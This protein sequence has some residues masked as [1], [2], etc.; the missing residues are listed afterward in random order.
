[1]IG[2]LVVTEDLVMHSVAVFESLNIGD[3][4]DLMDSVVV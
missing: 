2:L 4:D 3:I 1:M